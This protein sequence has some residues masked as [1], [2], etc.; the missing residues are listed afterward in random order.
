[1]QGVAMEFKILVYF[2]IKHIPFTGIAV[3]QF[4]LKNNWTLWESFKLAPVEANDVSIM[5]ENVKKYKKGDTAR[6]LLSI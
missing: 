1:M 5:Q 2:F 6:T 3:S 4:S